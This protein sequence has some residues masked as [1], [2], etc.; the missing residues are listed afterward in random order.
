MRETHSERGGSI[1]PTGAGHARGRYLTG[2]PGTVSGL[3]RVCKGTRSDQIK[4]GALAILRLANGW[5]PTQ[6]KRGNSR[7]NARL[8]G[9]AYQQASQWSQLEIS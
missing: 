2:P 9:R 3:L 5:I 1:P 6:G 4:V 7:G 8:Y